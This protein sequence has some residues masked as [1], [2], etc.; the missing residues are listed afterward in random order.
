MPLLTS[1]VRA[2]KKTREILDKWE[3]PYIKHHGVTLVARNDV[4]ECI[5]KI[6]KNKCSFNGYEGFT[7]FT[8]GSIQPHLEWS[9][10]WSKSTL[11]SCNEVI[12]QLNEASPEVTHYELSFS[13]KL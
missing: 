6:Y 1:N 2:M 7:L 8:N 5:N 11:P 9:A 3:V 4:S 10:S 12:V 13:E